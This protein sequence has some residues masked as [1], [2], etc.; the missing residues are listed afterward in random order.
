MTKNVLFS[1]FILSLISCF[2][3]ELPELSY[4]DLNP[5]DTPYLFDELDTLWT[6]P[7]ANVNY[8]HDILFS[9]KNVFVSYVDD[10]FFAGVRSYNSNN[11]VLNWDWKSSNISS[12]SSFKVS[13]KNDILVLHDSRNIASIN[14]ND[15]ST[16]SLFKD[17]QGIPTNPY[18]QLMGDYY[19]RS[20]GKDDESEAWILRSHVNDLMNWEKVFTVTKDQVDGSRPNPQSYNLWVDPDTK[21][22]ILVF[23]HRMAFPERIDIEAWNITKQ[24]SEWRYNDVAKHDNSNHQ[25]IFMLKDKAYFMAGATIYCFNI[26]GGEIVWQFN[27]PSGKNSFMFRKFAYC[28]DEYLLIHKDG[29]S[30]LAFDP[31]SGEL[32]YRNMSAGDSDVSAGSP[33]C[34]KGM[35]YYTAS[36]KLHAHKAS[37]GKLIWDKISKM[38]Y[39]SHFSGDIALDEEN[40]IMYVSDRYYLLAIN[41][42]E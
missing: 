29:S 32:V 21:D 25:Q 18:G 36:L 28:K 2:K 19:Y 9:D 33:V 26:K 7:L 3:D 6:V 42:H 38:D 22:E 8:V 16:K 11:G 17:L 41:F 31:D 27:H 13:A 1:I 12:P 20:H 30:L 24:K 23:Q 35:I 4:C 15:G 39:N 37:Q 34:A 10:N 40:G 14:L 5:C